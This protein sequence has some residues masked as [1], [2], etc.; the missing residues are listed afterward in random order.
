MAE[1]YFGVLL[2]FVCR[3]KVPIARISCGLPH[4]AAFVSVFCAWQAATAERSQK[5]RLFAAQTNEMLNKLYKNDK[6]KRQNQG[7]IGREPSK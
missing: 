4:D 1:F 3:I 5:M 2:F 6:M 7:G